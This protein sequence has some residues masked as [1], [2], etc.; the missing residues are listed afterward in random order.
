MSHKPI[1][2]FIGLMA[3]SVAAFAEK[4]LSVT[5]K[6]LGDIAKPLERSV[7]AELVSLNDSA[8]S[9]EIA[10]SVRSVHA[11]VGDYV[12]TKQVLARL[13][14]RDFDANLRQVNANIAALKAKIDAARTRV[15]SSQSRVA[16]A[17]A[18][19][20]AAQARV[21]ATKTGLHSAQTRITAADSRCQLARKQFQ[22]QQRLFQQH[23]ISND[24]FD[25]ARSQMETANAD[26]RA[27]RT[28]RET[29]N[30][31]IMAAQADKGAAD[32]SVLAAASD[33]EAAQADVTSLEADLLATKAQ[34][35]PV[36]LAIS[37]CEIKAPFAGQITK[38]LLQ[39]GQYVS[40]GGV[41]FQLLD[42]KTLEASAQFS[43][44]ELSS[45]AKAENRFFTT[46]QQRIKVEQRATLDQVVGAVRT[47]EIRFTLSDKHKLPSGQQGRIVWQSALPS[48][49]ASW[50]SRRDN[51][52]GVLILNEDK[53]VFVPIADA[54]E[55]QPFAIDLPTETRLVDQNRLRAKEGQTVKVIEE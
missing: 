25:Q 21:A 34:R 42:T 47:Q 50:L 51:Q 24:V 22:R 9:A 14:C 36:L 1:W 18:Q 44:S 13:D 35:E 37:R 46:N 32:A 19:A 48:L 20:Q 23:L 17:Q 30:A 2:L 55:G 53:V 52:L 41:T 3:I 15:Q 11:N 16:T 7:P 10:A 29:I 43:Q 26:C 38:R 31:N 33:V 5:V 45:L 39:Q 27:A 54:K 4:P 8:V 28:E 49:P 40:P 6:T 12:K